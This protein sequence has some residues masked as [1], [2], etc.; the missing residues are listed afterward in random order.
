[1]KELLEVV[2]KGQE[3]ATVYSDCHKAYPRAISQLDCQIK[4]LKTPGKEHRDQNNNLWEVNL[5]SSDQAHEFKPQ[6]GDPG[7]VQETARG[8]RAV[9]HLPGL[10]ELRSAEEGEGSGQSDAGD[11]EG[12]DNGAANPR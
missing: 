9:D 11:G 1:M 5:G 7:L 3:Q 6:A 4:H 10:A 2:L 12:S 8:S